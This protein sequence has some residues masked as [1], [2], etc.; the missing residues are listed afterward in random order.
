MFAGKVVLITGSTS[1]IGRATALLVAQRGGRATRRLFEREGVAADAW[2]FERGDVREAAVQRRLVDAAVGEFGRLDVLVNNAGVSG[3]AGVPP[4]DVRSLDHVWAVNF[5]SAFTL[6]QIAFPH[7]ARQKGAVV[8]VSSA[9]STIAVPA[10]AAYCVA[11]AALDHW[12]RIAALMYAPAGVRVN[13]VNPGFAKSGIASG[14]GLPDPKD[15]AAAFSPLC[16]SHVPQRR[17][18]RAAE[19][20]EVIALLAAD[21]AAWI[22]GAQFVVDGGLEAGAALPEQKPKEAAKK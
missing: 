2:H 16:R 18:G 19:V 14:L 3:L 22:T 15:F 20:A 13:S 9:T 12:T 21:R 1:G 4:L 17:L 8:N 11:K 5:R 6:T 7:L 10:F